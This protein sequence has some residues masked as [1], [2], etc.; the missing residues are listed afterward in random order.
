MSESS[1]V[2]LWTLVVLIAIIT[3]TYLGNRDI[4]YSGTNITIGDNSRDLQINTESPVSLEAGSAIFFVFRKETG[5]TIVGIP[6]K[7]KLGWPN[8]KYF[9]AG[10][11]KI[12]GGKWILAA[13][14]AS[15]TITS[16]TPIEVQ[17]VQKDPMLLGF[18]VTMLGLCIW[19]LGLIWIL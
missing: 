6:E 3:I 1:K 15:V 11:Q 8:D 4:N 2:F 19:L 18:L 17:A 5:E 10:P 16:E 13:G 12:P 7:P 14:S 9:H